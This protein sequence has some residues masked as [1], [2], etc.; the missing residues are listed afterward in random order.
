MEVD[1]RRRKRWGAVAYYPS[2]LL[3]PTQPSMVLCLE[4]MMSISDGYLTELVIISFFTYN[5]IHCICCPKLAWKLVQFSECFIFR[6]I[7]HEV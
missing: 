2:S 6:M 4:R 5:H 7:L 1:G 3:V